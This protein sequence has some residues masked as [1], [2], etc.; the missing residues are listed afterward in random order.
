[1]VLHEAV[2]LLTAVLPEVKGNHRSQ[3]SYDFLNRFSSD[4]YG[5]ETSGCFSCLQSMGAL[6]CRS[7][8]YVIIT[9]CF[10]G[11]FGFI[12][13]IIDHQIYKKHCT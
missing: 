13:L 9:V 3:L 12:G 11:I 5:G 2:L 1:M 4:Y 8:M 7:I 6:M 10:F